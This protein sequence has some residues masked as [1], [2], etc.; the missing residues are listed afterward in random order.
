MA[1]AVPGGLGRNPDHRAL[2]LTQPWRLYGSSPADPDRPHAPASCAAT[3][4]LKMPCT[5]NQ[6]RPNVAFSED[7][8]RLRVG[9]AALNANILRKMVLYLLNQ[10]SAPGVGSANRQLTTTAFTH[11][12]PNGLIV[13][14]KPY[15]IR[16]RWQGFEQRWRTQVAD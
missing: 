14:R 9:Y 5:G 13:V 8:L 11:R 3:G 2:S 1:R 10:V 7:C 15:R 4:A 6:T 16:P 12:P